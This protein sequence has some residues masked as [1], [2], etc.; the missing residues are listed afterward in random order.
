[1]LSGLLPEPGVLPDD[2]TAT[3]AATWSLS[4]ERADQIRPA[5]LARP[6]LQLAAMLDSEGIPQSVLTSGPA[7]DHLTTHRSPDDRG[8]APVTAEDAEGALRALDRLSLI[9]HTPET[10][11]QAVRVHRLIQR[12]TRDGLPSDQRSRVARTAA[13][14]LTAA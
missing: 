7:L 1:M 10:L 2:Q 13:D 11:H 3:V 12:A 8:P 5:G 4:I 14:T 6:M 9:D